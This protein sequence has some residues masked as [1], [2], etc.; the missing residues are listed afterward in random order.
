MNDLI[1]VYLIYIFFI[2]IDKFYVWIINLLIIES[3]DINWKKWCWLI[4]KRNYLVLIIVNLLLVFEVVWVVLCD[5]IWYF[6][7]KLIILFGVIFMMRFC[8]ENVLWIIM[9]RVML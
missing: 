5:E 3:L 1:C 8:F 9:I 6:F 7:L 2:I 4:V